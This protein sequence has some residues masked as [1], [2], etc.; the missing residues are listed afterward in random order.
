M[1]GELI[2]TGVTFGVGRNSINDQFSG[3]AEFNNIILGSGANF[4]GGLGSIAT[5]LTSFAFGNSNSVYAE[6]SSILGGQNNS[7]NALAPRSSIISGYQNNIS[8]GY[9]SNIISGSGNTLS[10]GAFNTPNN[11][12]IIGGVN[13]YLHSQNSVILGGNGLTGDSMNTAFMQIAY[14]DEYLDLNPQTTLPP[15]SIGRMFFSGTP[16]NRMMYNTGGTAS[17]WIII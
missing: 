9:N 7:I 11:S 5:G 17:D 15:A 10:Q 14:I 2:P 13:N 8:K 3:T 1:I 12:A 16:L 6:N 4:S